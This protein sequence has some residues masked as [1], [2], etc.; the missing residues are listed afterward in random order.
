MTPK[1]K[2][3]ELVEKMGIERVS[4]VTSVIPRPET[5]YYGWING[6]YAKQCALIAVDEI[7]KL[8]SNDLD[9]YYKDCIYWEQVKAEIQAP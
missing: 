6:K 9:L 4:I 1:E 5:T 3:K 7:L 2:A 8:V